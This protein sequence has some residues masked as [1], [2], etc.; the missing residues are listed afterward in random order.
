MAFGEMRQQDSLSKRFDEIGWALF[1]IMIGGIWLIPDKFP[2]DAWLIGA[3]LIILGLN[4]VRYL[5]GI[6]TSSFATILG[7]VALAGGVGGAFGIQ[8]SVL[9]LIFIVIGLSII[10]KPLVEKHSP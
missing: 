10:A 6:P 5:S 2:H 4:A 1:L 7:I 8:V 9:A 3:G